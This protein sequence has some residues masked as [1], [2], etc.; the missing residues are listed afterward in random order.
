MESLKRFEWYRD[1][2]GYRLAWLPPN[3][4]K[5][6][7]I[8]HPN[9]GWPENRNI[10]RSMRLDIFTSESRGE[11][12][13][14]K[15]GTYIAGFRQTLHVRKPDETAYVEK[16]RPFETDELVS[17]NLLKTAHTPKGWLDFTNKY[18][19]IGRQP[20][21]DHWHLSGKDKH[22]FIYQVEHEAEWRHLTNVL[23]RIYNDYPAIEKRDSKH[24]SKI[25]RWDSND[26]VREDRGIKIGRAKIRLPIAMRGKHP[27][28][29]DYL[30]HMKRPDVLT[31]A[32]FALRDYVNRYLEKSISLEVSFDYKS[33]K[34]RSS[35]RYGSLGT[36]LVAEAVEFMAGHFE[37]R[38]CAVCG[39]WFR[40]G[41]AQMRNDR[42]FCSA[43]C[44]MRRYRARKAE[45]A[46]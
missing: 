45:T 19:M 16:V 11:K 31:L 44:K 2:A 20:I 40:I 13:I 17:L 5:A 4:K 12:R 23:S 10:D 25:I 15:S 33:L 18:G 34:F 36:A 26:E 32:A 39:S 30:E 35:F 8:E 46:T 42:I 22:W 6:L 41:A 24:L 9:M 27:H 37:A 28:N 21:L 7:W 14:A 1:A 38:Q 29:A 3:S 43:A